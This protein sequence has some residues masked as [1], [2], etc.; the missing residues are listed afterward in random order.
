M[1]L[2]RILPP[3]IA[4]ALLV[5]GAAGCSFSVKKPDSFSI[6]D[7]KAEDGKAEIAPPADVPADTGPECSTDEQCDEIH[8]PAPECLERYCKE[9]GECGVKS[10]P[11]GT[12]CGEP[13]ECFVS[14]ICA[15]GKCEPS[16]PVDVCDDDEPCTEDE[17]VPGVGCEHTEKQCADNDPCTEDFCKPGVGCVHQTK[18][19]CPPK[20]VQTGEQYHGA[21]HDETCCSG[22]TSAP[23]FEQTGETGV[24]PP[25]GPCEVEPVCEEVGNAWVC[26]DCHN[27]ECEEWEDF[28]LCPDDCGEIGPPENECVM[29]GG[30]CEPAVPVPEEMACP[31]GWQIDHNYF[32]DEDEWC[33][34]PG[35]PP[36]CDCPDDD[37]HFCGPDDEC[38]PCFAEVCGD[39]WD[40]DCDGDTDENNCILAEVLTS[41]L[42]Q[43]G[44]EPVK[45]SVHKLVHFPDTFAGEVVVTAGRAVAADCSQFVEGPVCPL[46]L[47]NKQ[48]EQIPLTGSNMGMDVGCLPGTDGTTGKCHPL[49]LSSKYFVWGKWTSSDDGPGNALHLEGYCGD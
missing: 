17:C 32:C 7:V 2:P 37:F 38:Y 43:V 8:G 39:G 3:A 29:Q 1:M 41:C 11:P 36:G 34:M 44:N 6:V 19:D 15:A 27:G 21:Q 13:D 10:A 16:E 49:T 20:C 47:F 48:G 4:V 26:T 14:G 40:S 33:C 18:P 5:A 22:V 9:G 12:A 42:G 28:C 23:L 24:C 30:L 35:P 45:I 46:Y 31:E 25:D